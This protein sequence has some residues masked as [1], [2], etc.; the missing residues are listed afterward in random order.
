MGQGVSDSR[1]WGASEG[2]LEEGEG[3]EVAFTKA[4]KN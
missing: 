2:K 4:T 1:D 3:A